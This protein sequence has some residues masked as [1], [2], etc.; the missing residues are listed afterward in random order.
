MKIRLICGIL[1]CILLLTC[2]PAYIFA[3]GTEG[4]ATG[5]SE[6]TTP[7]EPT[8]ADGYINGV[9]QDLMNVLK[10]LEG[11]TPTCFWD[12]QQMSIGYGTVCPGGRN[13]HAAGS[14]SLTEEE[15]AAALLQELQTFVNA[16]YNFSKTYQ[17]KFKQHEFDALVCF[18][19]NLGASWANSPSNGLNQALRNG[20]TGSAMVYR[21]LLYGSAG[22]EY[23]LLGRRIVE[24]DMFINGV[25]NTN[26]YSASTYPPN[27][28]YV[29][30]DGAGGT[31]NYRV[32]GFDANDP[33][34]V[35]TEI[36]TAP[37]DA[38][39]NDC[40]FDGWYTQKE[41]GTKVEVLDSSFET[42][43]VIYAHWKDSRGE[44][45]VISEELF[46]LD[47]T[48]TGN[49]VNIRS[50]PQTYYSILGKATA[51]EKLRVTQIAKGD[52]LLWGRTERGWIALKYTD[53]DTVMASMSLSG[54]VIADGVNVRKGP[55][56]SYDSVG[57]KNTGDEVTV[58]GLNI[59]EYFENGTLLT[60]GKIGENEWICLDYVIYDP[61]PGDMDNNG[62]MNDRDAVLLL[63]YYLFPNDYTI[64]GNGDT[65]SDGAV[66]DRDA[67]HLLM[68]YLFPN[69]YVLYPVAQ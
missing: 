69:D 10:K 49:N 35:L 14:H 51:G 43:S 42:G 65:N 12:Y 18:S 27:Y 23:I 58:T 34:P 47:I 59:S 40:V 46:R 29:F 13:Q 52:S 63:M 5:E 66:N 8:D 53:Y 21:I 61:I 32:H 11:Y 62:V 7:T 9:S 56:T 19:Y 24:A 55:G 48:V 44:P 33:Q 4:D 17:I 64:Y 3:T 2:V 25:Y 41:G 16:V 28:R 6:T 45:I 39:G 20:V 1:V 60:W 68:H 36:K 50:G 30:A 31:V 38:Y 37:K 22:K 15:A 57:T 67:V 26:P 54:K